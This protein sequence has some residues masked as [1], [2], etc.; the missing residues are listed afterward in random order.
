MTSSVCVPQDEQSLLMNFN[1]T[2]KLCLTIQV[3]Y[4]A[5]CHMITTDQWF[6]S[7][8]LAA[9]LW[10]I[11]RATS[12]F[13]EI[14]KRRQKQVSLDRF[15]VK[16]ARKEKHSIGSIDSSDSVSDSESCPTQ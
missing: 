6:F 4:D 16:V 15:L 5:E 1:L 2:N 8:S 9:G 12:H 14:L 7:F 3:V 10:V 11:I 13:H